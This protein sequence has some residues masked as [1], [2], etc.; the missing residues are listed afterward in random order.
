[1]SRSNI[2]TPLPAD[3]TASKDAF[4]RAVPLFDTGLE[5]KIRER[6][7]QLYEVRGRGPGKD[8]Q[9]WLQA[10]HEILDQR[11]MDS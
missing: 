10:E 6:A 1:M 8:E 4:A 9:D 2:S 11:L 3:L 5:S 7:H